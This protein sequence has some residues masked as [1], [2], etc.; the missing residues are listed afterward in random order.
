MYTVI[1]LKRAKKYIDKLP[2]NEKK[3]L[4]AAIERLP[5][6]PGI[7]QMKGYEN[8]FRLRVADY[9]VIYRVDHGEL[10]VI[11]IDA[12]SRGDVYKKY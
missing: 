10:Q 9:R 1:L 11:V 2:Q 12:D 3:R 6:G 7:K 4:I 5:A 8:L